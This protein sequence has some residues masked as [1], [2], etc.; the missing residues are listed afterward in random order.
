MLLPRGSS[1][2]PSTVTRILLYGTRVRVDV[3]YLQHDDAAARHARVDTSAGSGRR[4][5]ERAN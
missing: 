1:T 3:T 4:R 2:D 5:T